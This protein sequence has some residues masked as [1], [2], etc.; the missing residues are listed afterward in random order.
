MAV[1]L[2]LT[3]VTAVN[4]GSTKRAGTKV[5]NPGAYTFRQAGNNDIYCFAL[6][7][8]RDRGA[9]HSGKTPAT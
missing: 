9:L 2:S 1:E 7:R 5:L 6:A 4:R 3:R 8:L